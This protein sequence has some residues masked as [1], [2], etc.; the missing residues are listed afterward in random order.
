MQ[1]LHLEWAPAVSSSLYAG[2]YPLHR[3]VTF[4]GDQNL[5][6]SRASYLVCGCHSFCWSAVCPSW[7]RSPQIIFVSVLPCAGGRPGATG[8]SRSL[9]RRSRPLKCAPWCLSR[10]MSRVHCCW[11]ASPPLSHT[12]MQ[13]I[14]LDVPQ[15]L[16]SCAT[17][18]DLQAQIP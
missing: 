14:D 6:L 3:E 16:C 5:Q 4:S 2:C 9:L 10:T 13:A 12:G 11:Q 1:G 17:S 18:S 8:R 7:S 15:V